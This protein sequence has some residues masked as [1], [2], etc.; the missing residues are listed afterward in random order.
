MKQYL[1][2]LLPALVCILSGVANGI[3]DTAT[4]H[5]NASRMV[6][7]NP[8][9]WNPALSWCN[10]WAGCQAGYER[11]PLSST[12]LVS[13]TDGWHLMKLL[14]S[15]L[16]LTGAMVFLAVFVYRSE[17]NEKTGRQYAWTLLL[18][19]TGA[20]LSAKICIGIGFHISYV[21]WLPV[22]TSIHAL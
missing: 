3:M 16:S 14:Y 9:Y 19:F 13:L 1:I 11:F 8:E 7:W 22:H 6:Y 10:K 21:W 20:L 17:C 5:Y 4:F 2:Y 15:L 18:C 12:V